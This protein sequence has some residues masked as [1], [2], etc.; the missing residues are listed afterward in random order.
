MGVPL[1]YPEILN[2]MDSI[3]KRLLTGKETAGDIAI[4]YKVSLPT[5]R[6]YVK[7]K[8]GAGTWCIIRRTG[9][10]I[11]AKR[12]SASKRN[13]KGSDIK[14]IRPCDNLLKQARKEVTSKKA[15]QEINNVLIS[16]KRMREIILED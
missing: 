16:M 8:T 6:K 12:R 2:D 5:L 1:K 4:E 11:A 7:K 9:Y 10:K 15:M 3:I 13:H 14:N